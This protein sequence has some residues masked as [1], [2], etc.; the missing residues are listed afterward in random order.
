MYFSKLSLAQKFSAVCYSCSVFYIWTE[1]NRNTPSRILE[2]CVL[3]VV[4]H[5]NLQSRAK[6]TW[7]WKE[8]LNFVHI[9]F[10]PTMVYN[11]QPLFLCSNGMRFGAFPLKLVH[12][13]SVCCTIAQGKKKSQR[14]NFMELQTA[15]LLSSECIRSIVW[16][17]Q[18]GALCFSTFPGF[19]QSLRKK[20][21]ITQAHSKESFFVRANVREIVRGYR[22]FQF[23]NW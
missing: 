7:T 9:T 6:I 17:L 20:T 1:F 8:S 18:S 15:S 12:K 3:R 19:K 13:K 4:F 21:G 2:K 11:F 23:C 14:P 22:N 10:N 5:L 16:I